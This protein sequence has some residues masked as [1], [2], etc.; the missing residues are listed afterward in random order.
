MITATSNVPNQNG[1]VC[2]E[3][4][5]GQAPAPHDDSVRKQAWG[6]FWDFAWALSQL[7]QLMVLVVLVMGVLAAGAPVVFALMPFATVAV[8]VRNR[9]KAWRP[10]CS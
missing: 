10:A 1:K 7:F 9:W 5:C 3:S 2:I 4:F 6:E 8:W